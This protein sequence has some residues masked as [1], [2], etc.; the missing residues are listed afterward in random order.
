MKIRIEKNRQKLYRKKKKK[1]VKQRGPERNGEESALARG[2]ISPNGS[3]SKPRE[4]R[5]AAKGERGG[6]L[7]GTRTQSLDKI[8]IKRNKRERSGRTRSR[9]ER[10]M[11]KKEVRK[12]KVE[13]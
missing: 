12:G 5:R 13:K 4:E 6:T 7:G 3:R 9:R 2:G 10:P 8:R 11:A 1:A